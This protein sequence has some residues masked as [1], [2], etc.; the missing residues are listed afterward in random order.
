MC[1][2]SFRYHDNKNLCRIDDSL[3]YTSLI[4]LLNSNVPL[5][6]PAQ[7]KMKQRGSQSEAA[8]L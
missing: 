3:H 1:H 2:P 6:S 7:F 8:L 4:S 5:F